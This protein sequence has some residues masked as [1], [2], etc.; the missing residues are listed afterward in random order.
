MT[1]DP[2]R[3][4]LRAHGCADP[5]VTGGLAGLIASWEAT[6][7]AVERGYTLGLDDYLNDMDAREL[8]EEALAVAPADSRR[9]LTARLDAADARMK[10]NVVPSACLWGDKLAKLNGWDASA[11]WWYFS[12]PREPGEELA[13]DLRRR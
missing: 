9:R 12:R 7:A 13:E 4:F 6:A 5:V 2:V 3:E 10:A 8:L 11:H 1:D